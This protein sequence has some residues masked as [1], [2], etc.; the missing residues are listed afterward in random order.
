MQKEVNNDDKYFEQ[1]GVSLSRAQMNQTVYGLDRK[2]CGG[3][4]RVSFVDLF[5]HEW[6]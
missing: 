2:M 4:A 1:R 6:R 5:V 3:A